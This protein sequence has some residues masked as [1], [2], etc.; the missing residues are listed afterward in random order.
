MD[1]SWPISRAVLRFAVGRV[2]P[3]APTLPYPAL[4]PNLRLCYAIRNT[5]YATPVSRPDQS[6]SFYRSIALSFD[7]SIYRL[8]IRPPCILSVSV[9][10]DQALNR[11]CQSGPR[12]ASDPCFLQ[13]P[14]SDH[15]S[16]PGA[17]RPIIA[18]ARCTAA[19]RLRNRI[20]FGCSE[21][22][23]CDL[24]RPH[25]CKARADAALDG[26]FVA[27]RSLLAAAVTIS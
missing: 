14:S 5:P 17:V 3:H 16:P 24:R 26:L 8:I 25:A 4:P 19:E 7:L 6:L 23:D 10:R 13:S 1:F 22:A 11:L 15:P 20:R 12:L 27:V 9:Q 21:G 18:L 2:L